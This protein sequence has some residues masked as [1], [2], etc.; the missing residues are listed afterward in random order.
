MRTRKA[1]EKFPLWLH[2]SGQWCKKHRGRNY[3]FGTDKAEALKR[4]ASQWDDIQAGRAPRPR[5]D[6]V[7]VADLANHFLSAKRDRLRSGELSA[8]MWSDYFTVC[9][10]PVIR[11]NLRDLR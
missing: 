9:E 1:A 3:Y 2:P 5:A 10:Q 8:R 7:T 11:K 4:Y 6:A